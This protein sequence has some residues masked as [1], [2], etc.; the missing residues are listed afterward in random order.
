MRS[1]EIV[2]W[3][4][5]RWYDALAKHLK[6]ETV[7]EKLDAYLDELI[8]QL[9]ERVYDR[10]SRELGEETLREQAEREAAR[11]YSAFDIRENGKG[12]IF[13]V[14]GEADILTV[15][16][17]LRTYVRG[18]KKD[19]F[20]NRIYGREEIDPETFIGMARERLD[21]TGK[22]AAAYDIDLDE[23]LFSALHIMDGWKT[24]R[25]QDVSTAVYYAMKPKD[26]N[27]DGRI[28]ELTQR[29]DGKE[30]TFSSSVPTVARGS[31]SLT[32]ADIRFSDE[33]LRFGSLLNFYVE[34]G[35]DVDAVFGTHVCTGENDDWLNVYATYDLDTAQVSD[36]LS[37]CLC[38]GDGTEQEMV[39][40]LSPVE[41]ELLDGKMREYVGM[42]LTEYA[43]TLGP[44]EDRGMEQTL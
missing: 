18:E 19:G 30:L 36:H 38:R 20:V 11:I 13:R 24:F 1:R 15:A 26:L 43:E 5:E 16:N 8:N 34:T 17:L 37:L 23:G 39:Y 6:D 7:E 35:F 32:E 40:P 22:V 44:E 31:R 27:R 10:I 3:L 2:L 4:D 28:Y 33:V 29:L 14:E 42:D 12:S 9:P 41:R 25:I 21:N